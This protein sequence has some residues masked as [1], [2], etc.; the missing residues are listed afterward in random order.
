M[1]SQARGK[2]VPVQQEASSTASKAKA[3]STAP[4]PTL[5]SK[6]GKPANPGGKAPKR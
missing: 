5:N 2:H 6:N 4:P 3:P 1:A